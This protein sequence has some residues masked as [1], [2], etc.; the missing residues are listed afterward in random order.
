MILGLTTNWNSNPRNLVEEGKK[1]GYS[2]DKERSARKQSRENNFQ[3]RGEHVF[4][5]RVERKAE[6]QAHFGCKKP[7][8]GS[9]YKL[10]NEVD[11]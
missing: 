7:W 5:S 1:G 11:E 10:I 8:A 3:R 2:G 9:H 4:D 6:K